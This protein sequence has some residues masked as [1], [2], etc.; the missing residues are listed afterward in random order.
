MRCEAKPIAASP[1]SRAQS[2]EDNYR[3]K[4]TTWGLWLLGIH[5]TSI[6]YRKVALLMLRS[7]DWLL[8][9][10]MNWSLINISTL[11][12][13]INMI[14]YIAKSKHTV[15]IVCIK[16]STS[17]SYFCLQWNREEITLDLVINVNTFCLASQSF[18]W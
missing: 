17:Y 7:G 5:S 3:S 11:C 18:T 1:Y 13:I 2:N 10:N 15:N 6:S 16:Y 8:V 4:M 14:C 12:V 9:M